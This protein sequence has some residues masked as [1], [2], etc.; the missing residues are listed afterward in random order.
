M[1]LRYRCPHCSHLLQAHE[2]RA[3]KTSVCNACLASHIIPADRTQWLNE[4]GEPLLSRREPTPDSTPQPAAAA[5][6]AARVTAVESAPVAPVH[7]ESPAEPVPH[8][9]ESPEPPTPA[10]R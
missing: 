9:P 8:M 3:G 10:P 6:P 4:A 2:L 1:M 5:E 7:V